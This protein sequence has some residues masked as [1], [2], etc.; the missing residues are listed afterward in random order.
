MKTLQMMLK[1]RFDTSNYEVKRPLPSEKNKKVIGLLKDKLGG[2]IIT[3]FK[4]L[5]PKTYC[6]LMNDGSN[7]K[8]AKGTKKCVIKQILKFNYYKNCLPNNEIVLK[9][10]QKFKTEAHNVYTKKLTRLH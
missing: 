2:N 10:Q 5:R 1:K 6:Q 3:E 4:A 7:N 8:K 9:S